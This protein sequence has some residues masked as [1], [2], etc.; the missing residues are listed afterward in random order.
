MK[1]GGSS[2]RYIDTAEACL[3]SK[4]QPINFSLQPIHN[5]DESCCRYVES[6]CYSLLAI[7]TLRNRFLD[8]VILA[9]VVVCACV[10]KQRYGVRLINSPL[11]SPFTT[12]I[13]Q[14]HHVHCYYHRYHRLDLR[15][16]RRGCRL[17]GEC[18]LHRGWEGG[19]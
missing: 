2:N 9:S 13:H 19:Q 6:L 15:R 14:Y 16:V 3:P 5:H 8:R 18:V 4:Q 12:S 7:T 17:Y 1:V 10:S 11:L